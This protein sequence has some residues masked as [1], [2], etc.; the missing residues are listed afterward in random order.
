MDKDV[1]AAEELEHDVCNRFK[2]L[3]REQLQA[4]SSVDL[5]ALWRQFKNEFLSQLI[6]FFGARTYEV[7]DWR[8]NGTSTK[9]LSSRISLPDFRQTSMCRLDP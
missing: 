7:P 9:R 4:H 2:S 5:D 6:E 1:E 3:A 8:R